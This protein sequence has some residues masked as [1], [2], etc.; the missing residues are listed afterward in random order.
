MTARASSAVRVRR[1]SAS[2][3]AVEQAHGST[4]KQRDQRQKRAGGQPRGAAAADATAARVFWLG[5]RGRRITAH[6]GNARFP[7]WTER[8][9]VDDTV[10]VV[11]QQ[12]ADFFDGVPWKTRG[13]ITV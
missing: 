12:I 6:G 10:A 9:L 11:I 5:C 7:C 4:R 8:P 1:A 2:K 3:S 13:G